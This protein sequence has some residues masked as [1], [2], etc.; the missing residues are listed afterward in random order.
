MLKKLTLAAA[1]GA[2]YVLGAKAGKE[3]YAQIEAKFRDVAGMPAVQNATST[4]KATAGDLADSAKATAA[5]L[6]DAANKVV[7]EKA[8]AVVD[9]AGTVADKAAAAKSKS[10]GTAAPADPV[11][12]LSTEPGLAGPG[13]APMPGA[14]ASVTA[15]DALRP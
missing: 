1:F 14:S 2:G 6:A 15:P 11:I 9:K 10:T 5:D 3:R 4:V 13:L 7:A 12:D 8:D